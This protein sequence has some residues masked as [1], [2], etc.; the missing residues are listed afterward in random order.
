[1]TMLGIGFVW[2]LGAFMQMVLV[3]FGLQD[4]GQTEGGSARLYTFLAVGIALGAL[5]AGRLS[6][7]KVEPGL[8]PIGSMG[9][10]ACILLLSTSAPSFLK[11]GL[12]LGLFGVALGLF[13]VPLN[14]LLQQRADEREKGRLMAT[15]N[16][17]NTL[18]GLLAAAAVFGLTKWAHFTSAE[19]F[20]VVGALTLAATIVVL[21]LIPDFFM[22]FVLWMLTHTVYRIKIVGRPNIPMRGPALIIA[23]HVSMIDGALIGACVQRFVR[24]LVYGPFMRRPILG[25]CCANCARFR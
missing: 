2:F 10:G 8:V 6:G 18:G 14:A 9:M 16:V 1:M 12:S 20:I 24:F 11:A 15:S 13:A 19:L 7:D 5:A 3:P 22:R 17:V 25:R 4:L 23:N 21:T